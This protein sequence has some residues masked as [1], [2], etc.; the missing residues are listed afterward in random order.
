MREP[1]DDPASCAGKRTQKQF[2]LKVCR[3]LSIVSSPELPARAEVRVPL[4]LRLS[5]CGGL[6]VLVWSVTA[7][8]LPAGVTLAA[9]GSLFGAPRVA[10]TYRFTATVT[11]S[12]LRSVSTTATLTVAARLLLPRQRLAAARV[13]Q[14]YWDELRAVGGVVPRAWKVKRGRLPSGIRLVPAL[15]VLTGTPRK[16]GTRRVAVEVRDA[17]GARSTTTLTLVVLA[18]RRPDEGD[19]E[20]ST[21]R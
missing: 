3:R 2:T 8:E 10:G 13:G 11:D 4:R 21:S 5:Y 19:R 1:Q 15:G 14:V 9:D 18:A 6:G 16:A 20:T 12:Q 7:G 17:L